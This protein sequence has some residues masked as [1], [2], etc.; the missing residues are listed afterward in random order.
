[1]TV[2]EREYALGLRK[3]RQLPWH[4]PPHLDFEV[5]KQYLVSSSCYD[6]VPIIGKSAER[7]TDFE[8]DVLDVFRELCSHLFAWCVLPNHYHALVKTDRIKELR[9]SLGKLH[10]RTSFTWNGEDNC[11]GRQ[12]WY[13]CF[14]RPMKSGRHFWTTLNYVHHNP[15]HHGYV[16][17]WQDWPWSSAAKYLEGVG[18][19]RAKQVWKDYPL[20]DY[21]KKWDI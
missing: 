8:H 20:L 19:E 15:V 7:M 3:A 12:V 17:K 14:E 6:H 4:N 16:K 9:K 13:N 21:G 18:T 11:R 2:A 5:S 1:M 10:G